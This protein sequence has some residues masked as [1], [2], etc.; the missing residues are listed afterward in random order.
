MKKLLS[1]FCLVLSISVNAQVKIGHKVPDVEFARV[2]NTKEKQLS[3]AALQGKVVLLEFWATWCEPCIK[4]MKHLEELQETYGNRLQIITIATESEKRIEKF[5]QNKPSSLWF[6]IDTARKFADIFPYKIIPHSVLIDGRGIVRAITEP[7]QISEKVIGKMLAGEA[8][9]LPFKQDSIYTDTKSIIEK[10]FAAKPG[11]ENRFLIQPEIKGISSFYKNYH[12]DAHFANRRLTMINLPLSTIYRIAY[13]DISLMRTLDLTTKKP[14]KGPDESYCMDI[15]V[16][17]GKEA[18]LLSHLKEGLSEH[19]DIE[20]VLEKRKKKV[21]VLELTRTE[22]IQRAISNI[23]EGDFSA[24]GDAFNGEGVSLEKIAQYLE[25]FGVVNLPVVDETGD[26]KK[27]NI[28][29]TFEPENKESLKN[30]LQHIGLKLKEA[31][32]EIEILVLR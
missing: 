13:K 14:N 2:L 30:A 1:I 18:D 5:L 31:Q 29:F 15:I 32:R 12:K 11:T 8:I 9:S 17:K 7:S 3:L 27:Y 22:K 20:A 19:Y 16:A 4:D 21:Y 26:S 24:R 25:Q 23:K 10:Y 28:S 6:A